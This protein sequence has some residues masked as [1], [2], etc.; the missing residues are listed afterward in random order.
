MADNVLLCIIKR[1]KKW[2]KSLGT[3]SY[4]SILLLQRGLA[5]GCVD[6]GVVCNT[7]CQAAG[8]LCQKTSESCCFV[9]LATRLQNSKFYIG[10]CLEHPE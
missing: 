8:Q 3:S 2:E 6:Q 5:V 9:T 1:S 10:L 4:P 7:D